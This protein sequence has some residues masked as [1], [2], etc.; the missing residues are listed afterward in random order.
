MVFHDILCFS[1]ALDQQLVCWEY[2]GI[3]LGPFCRVR[4]VPGLLQ[5]RCDGGS[6]HRYDAGLY[7]A[8]KGNFFSHLAVGTGSVDDGEHLIAGMNRA[9][10]GESKADAGDGAGDDQLFLTR[11]LDRSDEFRIVAVPSPRN[12]SRRGSR[13]GALP[14]PTAPDRPRVRKAAPGYALRA[15]PTPF[16]TA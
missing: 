1:V 12:A 16:T 6:V 2:L 14:R 3:D 13:Y 8:G 4:S 5:F 11:F 10:R 15:F 7:D 9:D